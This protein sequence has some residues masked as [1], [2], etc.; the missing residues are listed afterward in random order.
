MLPK[1][2]MKLRVAAML[3]LPSLLVSVEN[4]GLHFSYPVWG[5]KDRITAEGQTFLLPRQLLL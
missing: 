3:F 2:V 4:F 5:D 1:P